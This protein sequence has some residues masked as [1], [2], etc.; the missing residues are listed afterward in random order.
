MEGAVAVTVAEP[1]TC[2]LTRSGTEPAPQRMEFSRVNEARGVKEA[3]GV[4][5]ERV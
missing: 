5:K 4:P 1:E 3:E 2:R